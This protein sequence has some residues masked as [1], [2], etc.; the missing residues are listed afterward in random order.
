MTRGCC[1]EGLL[2]FFVCSNCLNSRFLSMFELLKKARSRLS[3]RH[4][5]A[6]LPLRAGE[7][8]MLAG[9]KS[10]MS[11][12]VFSTKVLLYIL[13]LPPHHLFFFCVFFFVSCIPLLLLEFRV[14]LCC[15]PIAF[16][17][18][19]L[20]VLLD[21]IAWYFG[22]MSVEHR[23]ETILPSRRQPA[24]VCTSCAWRCGGT[25]TVSILC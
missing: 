16:G 17:M 7:R 6:L 15:V 2:D 9:R 25:S 10:A 18:V 19:P 14:P 22:G 11:V 20:C 13:Y 21:L 12:V 23:N 4:P 5:W 24:A 8:N 3:G 1:T